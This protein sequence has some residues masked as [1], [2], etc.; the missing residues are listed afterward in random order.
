MVLM[1]ARVAAIILGG[2]ARA[3]EPG[4]ELDGFPITRHQ[5]AVVGAANVR[6]QSPVPTLMLG[7]M[8]ASPS[9]VAILRPRRLLTAA[10]VMAEPIK[11]D[12][13]AK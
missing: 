9:Q 11:V 1:T 13:V 6:E 7:G 5:V 12:L 10:T 3:A 8:P 4:Y 2:A